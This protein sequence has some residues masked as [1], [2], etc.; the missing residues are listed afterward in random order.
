MFP[1][2]AKYT[3]KAHAQ[4][5]VY[6]MKPRKVYDIPKTDDHNLLPYHQKM[7]S[8]GNNAGNRRGIRDVTMQMKKRTVETLVVVDRKMYEFHETE[9][10]IEPYVLTIM[11]IVSTKLVLI[12]CMMQN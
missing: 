12:K 1:N 4:S 5:L 7:D 3:K 11:N 6:N 10:A 9:N 8:R 2:G